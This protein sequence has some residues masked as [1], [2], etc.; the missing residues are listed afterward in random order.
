MAAWPDYAAI[1][2]DYAARL[3]PQTERAIWDDGAVRQARTTTRPVLLREVV[4][5]VP[6]A[7]FEAFRSWAR[8][9][10]RDWFAWA[11]PGADGAVHSARVVGGAHGIAYAQTARGGAPAWEARMTLEGPP[12]DTSIWDAPLGDDSHVY[13]R[14]RSGGGAGVVKGAAPG[15]RFEF[16]NSREGD[17]ARLPA[18]WTDP[19][20]AWIVRASVREAAPGTVKFR[21]GAERLPDPWD[22]GSGAG[23]Q[24]TAAARA[25]LAL[26]LRCG[27]A[28]ISL[29]PIGG[30]GAG[31]D[32]TEPYSWTPAGADWTRFRAAVAALGA[33]VSACLVWAGPGSVI[34]LGR[35]TT[36]FGGATPAVAR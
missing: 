11:D 26:C 29:R 9:H 36:R 14:T 32:P 3:A 21:L 19:G 22:A 18:A 8:A 12:A 15:R 33:G 20:P 34:D 1:G 27:D 25:G 30:A 23:P 5:H 31:A 17:D 4:A 16:F 24:L 13:A 2:G 10:A 6:G 7:R 28:A 35:R